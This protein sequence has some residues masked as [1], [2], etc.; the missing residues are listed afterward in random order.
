[1]IGLKRGIVKLSPYQKSW[2]KDFQKEKIELEKILGNNIVTIEHCGSTSVEGLSAKPIIDVLVGVKTIKREGKKCNK[3]LDPLTGY[4]PRG[5]AFPK[6]DRFV[7]AKGNDISR[8]HY[9]HI[10]RYNGAIWK[11]TL[12]FRDYLRLHRKFAQEY[13]NLKDDLQKKHPDE[14]R[15]YTKN[16]SEFVK[17]VLKKMK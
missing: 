13:A 10:V 12:F 1:M 6:K 3:I 14:R 8:T 9:I 16:K 7:V 5:K 17:E 11:K 4:F 15:T 2:V